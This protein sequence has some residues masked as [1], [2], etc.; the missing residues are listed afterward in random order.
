MCLPKIWEKTKQKEFRNI[1]IYNNLQQMYRHCPVLLFRG[2]AWSKGRSHLDHCLLIG[3]IGGGAFLSSWSR[4]VISAS[5]YCLLVARLCEAIISVRKFKDLRIC[6]SF[7]GLII[8]YGYQN[9]N[10]TVHYLQ[11]YTCQGFQTSNMR[12]IFSWW[13]LTWNQSVNSSKLSIADE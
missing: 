12:N 6:C 11:V 7:D 13:F 9:C 2:G 3:F 5:R 10:N 1:L 8:L 4:L